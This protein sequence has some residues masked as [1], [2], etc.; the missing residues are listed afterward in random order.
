M[1]SSPSAWKRISLFLN[2]LEEILLGSF[3]ILMVLLGFLQILFRNV[4]SVGLYW[5]DPLMRHMVLWLALLGASV[6][7]RENRHISIDLLSEKL[8]HKN[9]S[10]LQ[11]GINFFAA[12]IC[13]ILVWPAIRF[14][15]EEYEVGKILAFNIPIWA[16]Q[17]VIPL[18]LTVLGLR[19]LSKTWNAF[20]RRREFLSSEQSNTTRI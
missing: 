11:G 3:L 4:I 16:S 20:T 6:A 15:Q 8:G 1:P 2:R 7:T 12:A 13:L 17:S 14:V 19:F 5:I 10:Y 18:M 9:R